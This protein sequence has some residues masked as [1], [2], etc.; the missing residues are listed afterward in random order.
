[1]GGP[2]KDISLI[3]N[4][5][6]FPMSQ[7]DWFKF[8]CLIQVGPSESIQEILKTGTERGTQV[9]PEGWGGE[10]EGALRLGRVSRSPLQKEVGLE[11]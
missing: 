11:E 6:L 4:L 5:V 1:M 10:W 3:Y 8:G 7:S 2:L 9:P